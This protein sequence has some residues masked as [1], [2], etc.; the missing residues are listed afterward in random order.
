MKKKRS[1]VTRATRCPCPKG[2]RKRVGP[3]INEWERGHVLNSELNGSSR[4]LTH[5]RK[6]RIDRRL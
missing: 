1:R 4:L 5:V 3:G 2:E 6:S